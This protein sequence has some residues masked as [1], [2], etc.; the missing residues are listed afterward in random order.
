MAGGFLLLSASLSLR[1]HTN[2]G[3]SHN[4]YIREMALCHVRRT[5]YSSQK[6]KLAVS[7]P[8]LFNCY[9]IIFVSEEDRLGL[10]SCSIHGF[11]H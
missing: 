2:T 10:V 6:K 3:T 4:R 7:V 11:L 5:H 8:N 9:E 1:T